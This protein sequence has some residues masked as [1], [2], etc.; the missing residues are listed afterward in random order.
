MR[1]LY[2][3]IIEHPWVTLCIGIF[4]WGC[5][6]LVFQQGGDDKDDEGPRSYHG[7]IDH[8]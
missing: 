3:L 5:L 7:G 4:I 6:A 1:E 2:N 8:P